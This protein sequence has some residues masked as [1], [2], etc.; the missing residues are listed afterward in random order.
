MDRLDAM[1]LLVAVTENGSLSATSRALNVPL[2][3]LSRKISELESHLGTRL[4]T[5]TTRKLSLTDAG[6]SY[7]AASRRI[8]EQVEEAEREAAGEL[9]APKGELV[10][11]APV[12]FGRLHVIPVIAEFLEAFAEINVRLMLTDRNV[13]LVSDH[14]DLAVRIGK[15]PDSSMVATRLGVMREVTCASSSLLAKRGAPQTPEELQVYPCV[16]VDGPMPTPSW[17]YRRPETG[18][19]LEVRIHPRLTVTTPE[20]AVHAALHQVGIVRLLH[21]QVA[22]GLTHGDFQLILEAFE[23]QAVPVHLVHVSRKHMPLKIRRFLDFAAPQLK[24]AL[25]VIASSNADAAP[26][27]AG[28]R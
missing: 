17:R 8:L 5:R 7:V 24:Q 25:A 15:L 26:T 28:A 22:D 20:S 9:I 6:V 23:P 11:T 12:M 14:V 18:S 10:I 19:T 2:A 16:T 13:D 1:S 27:P 21:Y 3:T 4:L